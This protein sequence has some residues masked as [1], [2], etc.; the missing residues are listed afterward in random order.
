MLAFA[1]RRMLVA[2]PILLVS[3]ILVFAFMRATTNPTAGLYCY[4]TVITARNNLIYGNQ[5]ATEVFGDSCVHSY[6]VIGPAGIRRLECTLATTTSSWPSR[7][8]R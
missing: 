4:G 6:S 5:T 3:S 7:S 8:S 2:I 1:A